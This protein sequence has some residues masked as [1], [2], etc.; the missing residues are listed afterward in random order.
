MRI[1]Q[2][3]AQGQVAEFVPNGCLTVRT[4]V[5]AEHLLTEGCAYA[6]QSLRKGGK[7]GANN[8]LGALMAV[9]RNTR[10]MF[11]HAVQVLTSSAHFMPFRC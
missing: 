4:A 5:Q 8:F 1:S 11:V 6:P 10:M 7:E 2:R 9:P 3:G